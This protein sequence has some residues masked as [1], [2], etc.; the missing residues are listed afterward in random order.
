MRDWLDQPWVRI[1]LACATGA[2]AS[3]A[4]GRWG[5]VQ[6]EFALRLLGGMVATSGPL[7]TSFILT[8]PLLARDKA[9]RPLTSP[10]AQAGSGWLMTLG[11]AGLGYLAAS[12]RG[13]AALFF[14]PAGAALGIMALRDALRLLFAIVTI[15]EPQ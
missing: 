14:V 1:G 9:L 7:A 8:A 10:C 6:P 13:A 11:A 15:E 5:P 12:V 4:A 3:V 2:A